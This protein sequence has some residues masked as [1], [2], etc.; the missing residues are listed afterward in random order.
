VARLLVEHGA[1]LD[2]RDN[3]RHQTALEWAVASEQPE[4]ARALGGR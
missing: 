4:V 1:D 3:E 2:A